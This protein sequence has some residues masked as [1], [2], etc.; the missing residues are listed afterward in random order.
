MDDI[1]A[2]LESNAR[3]R[4]TTKTDPAGVPW[5]PLAPATVNHWYAIKYPQG[6]PGTL[7]QRTFDRCLMARSCVIAV[8]PLE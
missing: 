8:T 7:L 5:P 6:I 4:F 2:L 3:L 1:G